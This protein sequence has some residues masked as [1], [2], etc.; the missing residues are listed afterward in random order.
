LCLENLTIDSKPYIQHTFTVNLAVGEGE[1]QG[2]TSAGLDVTSRTTNDNALPD[3]TI[4]GGAAVTSVSAVSE[5]ITI[6]DFTAASSAATYTVTVG[7]ANYTTGSVAA[8]ASAGAIATALDTALSAAGVTVAAT[9]GGDLTF[10]F[11]T[12]G[13]RTDEASTINFRTTPSTGFDAGTATV[14]TQGVNSYRAGTST[15]DI[16]TNAPVG[17]APFTFGIT[18]LTSPLGL[19]G[20]VTT[21]RGNVGFELADGAP[22]GV[23]LVDNNNGTFTAYIDVDSSGTYLPVDA[24]SFAINIIDDNGVYHQE[25]I[26]LRTVSDIKGNVTRTSISEPSVGQT[27]HSLTAV[28]GSHVVVSQSQMS[29]SMKDFVTSHT[30]GSFTISG[31]DADLFRI[32]PQTGKLSSKTFVD[33]EN[34][35][36]AGGNNT[37]NVTITYSSDADSFID[38]LSLNI[39][40]SSADD[41][42]TQA[43]GRPLVGRSAIEAA[44]LVSEDEDFTIYGNVGTATIDVNG[45]ASAYEIVSAINGRQGETG[46]YA[47]AVTRVNISFP[48]QFDELDD[49]VSFML[50]G[51]NDEPVL[52]SGS[53]E[54]GLVGG[55]DA[56]VRGLADAI[57]GVSG[58][59]GITAKVSINGSTLHLIS[60]EGHDIVVED[61]E[62]SVLN[63]PMNV[64]AANDELETVGDTQQLFK[65]T[66]EDD[67]FRS[68]G[69]IIFHSPY[70][71][72]IEANRTGIDGGGLFQLTPGAAKLSSV[73]SLD[74]LTVENAKKMLTAVDGALVRI[75]LERSDLGATMSRMEHTIANLSNVVVN[76]KA[77]R[78]RIQDADIAEETTEMTKAQVLAQAAQAM[79]AQA[80]RT[81]QSILS[82]LQG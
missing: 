81:S 40:N 60:N 57:N 30:G 31:A 75:D 45:G 62:M 44:S 72:S 10:T 52:V 29:Q 48:D 67:T 59:T 55:R 26:S 21:V 51:L 24:T 8:S 41:V 19:S 43:A 56:N 28:E 50:K 11:D 3:N 27:N 70:V 65:G 54:F 68:T 36:D 61:F 32:D 63:I 6:A 42:V 12:G 80:N 76:T 18:D 22:E 74:V 37:Y 34:P 58:K 17:T 47:N 5:V 82:L 13:E 71:F 79:L 1:G 78:S 4:A 69:E 64:A 35:R 16:Q 20:A 25:T 46:V 14:S 33:F 38:N 49:A 23:R 15:V 53:V 39:T 66:T 7:G 2:V 77:A 73:A 9:A